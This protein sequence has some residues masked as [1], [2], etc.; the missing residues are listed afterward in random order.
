MSSMEIGGLGSSS[1]LYDFNCHVL[2]YR[3][4]ALGEHALSSLD[5]NSEAQRKEIDSSLTTAADV[6]RCSPERRSD[7]RDLAMKLFSNESSQSISTDC[8]G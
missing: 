4:V 8:Q 3:M 1:D 2:F 7:V 5:V 6:M